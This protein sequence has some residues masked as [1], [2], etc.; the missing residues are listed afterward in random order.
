MARNK[1]FRG[2]LWPNGQS[3]K[4]GRWPLLEVRG[5]LGGIFF[6]RLVCLRKDRGRTFPPAPRGT[7]IR[8]LSQ[9]R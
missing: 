3:R 2:W 9:P 8:P 4:G 5:R 6:G 1:T 7:L